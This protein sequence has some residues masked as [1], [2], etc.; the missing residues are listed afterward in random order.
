M[1]SITISR[2]GLLW[3]MC[4]CLISVAYLRNLWLDSPPLIVVVVYT[5]GFIPAD[6][7]AK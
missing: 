6:T 4:D 7:I 2:E 3:G 5:V 1:N